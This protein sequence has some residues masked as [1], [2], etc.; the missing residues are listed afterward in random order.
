MACE[1]VKM[2]IF[3]A[4]GLVMN[5]CGG[6]GGKIPENKARYK[7]RFCSS[8]CRRKFYR[9]K[10]RQNNPQP[11]ISTGSMGAVGEMIVASDLLLRGFAV[12]RAVSQSSPCDLIAT[13]GDAILR[14]EVTKG[15]RTMLGCVNWAKH[16]EKNYDHLAI[17]FSDLTILYLPPLGGD[18][19][20]TQPGHN[21]ALASSTELA[22]HAR[23]PAAR[24]APR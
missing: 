17:Y 22:T 5:Q 6:C 4:G 16:D 7:A 19:V 24:T 13:R 10:Y 12:Y 3:T 21:P 14:V 20:D 18:A 11:V 1:S 2:A 15:I 8:D 9:D 23:P